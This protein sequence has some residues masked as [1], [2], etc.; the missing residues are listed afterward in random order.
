MKLY[1]MAVPAIA[2]PP[3]KVKTSGSVL[4]EAYSVSIESDQALN[5]CFDAFSLREPVSTSLENALIPRE[6]H[7][8]VQSGVEK[9]A[10][11]LAGNTTKVRRHDRAFSGREV[12]GLFRQ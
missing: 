10:Q 9:R 2:W 4:R 6:M 1:A 3:L 11:V 5:F 7:V 12:T 8:H